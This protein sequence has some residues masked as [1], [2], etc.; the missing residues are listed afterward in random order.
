[1]KQLNLFFSLLLKADERAIIPPYLIGD[2]D[3][4]GIQDL[5]YKY[6]IANVKGIA[7]AKRY[8]HRLFPRAEGGMFYCN[9]IMV[10]SKSPSNL[11]ETL[12][13]QLRDNSMGLWQRSI[14]AEQV[15]EIGWLLYSTRQQNDKWISSLLSDLTEEK[16]G[17]R[18]RIICTSTNFNRH[19]GPQGEKP[20]EVRAIHLECDAN[21]LLHAKHKVAHLFWSSAKNVP[22]WDQ[23]VA[24]PPH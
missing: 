17:A 16:I 14:D 11:M 10:T 1:M 7:S 15:S 23:N 12:S 6:T 19:K 21:V 9:V 22:R 13:T 8:F 24:Y 4:R 2:R 5:S 3:A 18:W 20:L